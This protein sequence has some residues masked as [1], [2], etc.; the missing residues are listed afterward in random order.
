ED[1]RNLFSAATGVRS[2]V[3]AKAVRDALADK[4]IA[5]VIIRVDSPGGSYVASDTIWRE[6]VKAK[7]KK[8][9]VIVSMGNLAASGGYFISMPA[10]R[11]FAQPATITGS[12]GVVMGKVVIGG[13]LDKLDIN[14]DRI[15]FGESAGIFSSA[16]DFSPTQLARLN[17]ML[18]ATYADFTGKAAQGRGK[19]Q[20][21]IEKVAR[22]RVWTGKDALAN[23]LVD[24][25]GGLSKA[26][27]YTKAKVGLQPTDTL[28]LV[29]FPKPKGRLAEFLSGLENPDLPFGIM[30][31]LHTLARIGDVM[32]PVMNE[33]ESANRPGTQ[34]YMAPMTVK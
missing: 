15:T 23:G 29:P 18:D 1:E 16:T 27:D 3:M 2:G 13:A 22:G 26:I 10:D 24:E 28:E 14:F 32:S 25:L 9:P 17:Q 30:S 11:I 20:E 19:T 12:I 7:D 8:K 4:D 33:L 21:E 31:A 6:V 5:A 34:L